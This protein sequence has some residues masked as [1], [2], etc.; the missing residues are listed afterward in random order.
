MP[1]SAK[2]EAVMGLVTGARPKDSSEEKNAKRRKHVLIQPPPAIVGSIS[3]PRNP[4]LKA[5]LAVQQ[6]Y[7]RPKTLE[8]QIVDVTAMLI[9]EQLGAAIERFHV[10]SCDRCCAEITARAM[11]QL[12]RIF[13]HVRSADDEK[14]VNERLELMR[15]DV[16]KI[17]AK[18]IISTK[19]N[20]VH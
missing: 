16:V 15:A 2:T 13:M 20:P 1:R 6:T 19:T 12:P 11:R 4:A 9:G 3:E 17:L 10:C 8:Y 14:A 18:V 7:A 5:A